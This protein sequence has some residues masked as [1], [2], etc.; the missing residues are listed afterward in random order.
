MHALGATR[1]RWRKKVGVKERLSLREV[2]LVKSFSSTSSTSV[3]IVT[4]LRSIVIKVIHRNQG[5]RDHTYQVGVSHLT[6][7]DSVDFDRRPSTAAQNPRRALPR[8]ARYS[9][10]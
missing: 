2:L 4:I 9:A 5:V 1:L 8:R 10:V 7:V 6:A 3:I